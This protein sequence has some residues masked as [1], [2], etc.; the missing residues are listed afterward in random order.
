MKISIE[1]LFSL[2]GRTCIV[3]GGSRGIGR[4]CANFIAAAGANLAIIGTRQDTAQ[5]AAEEIAEEYGVKSLGFACL[6]Q[7]REE[8]FSM[9]AAVE[10]ELG[11]VD[12]LHNN[13]GIVI[14]GD[15]EDYPEESW[16]QTLDINLNGAFFVMQAVAQR[17]FEL[18]KP[19]SFVNTTSINTYVT[20]APLHESA[21]NASK[22]GLLMLSRSL[23]VEWGARG[24]RV[25]CISPGVTKT[26]MLDSV[27]DQQLM[28]HWLERTPIGFLGG[29]NDLG[30]AVLYL[31]SDASKYT[32]GVE[33]TVDGAYT[34]I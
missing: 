30:G 12:L 7:N 15:S 24:I 33:I 8:V 3:T 6:V 32:T 2:E 17:L 1:K 10:K 28:N 13:A 16:R 11:V 25:N 29:P 21:Y 23:A 27:G 31:L 34:I 19:G 20:S 4:A 18:K 22:A 14:G 5:K 26:D 9:V